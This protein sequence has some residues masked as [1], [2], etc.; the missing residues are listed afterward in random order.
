[1]TAGTG[2]SETEALRKS[3][4]ATIGPTLSRE[5]GLEEMFAARSAPHTLTTL[6]QFV[7]E[8]LGGGVE[9]LSQRIRGLATKIGFA[10]PDR[11]A[12]GIRFALDTPLLAVLVNG[13]V[14]GSTLSFEQFVTRL[15]TELGLVL[16]IGEDDS[17]VEQLETETYG[18]HGRSIYDV[19]MENEQVLRQRLIRTGLART[20]SDAH[21]EVISSDA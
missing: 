8:G 14:P 17:F 5:I 4:R 3:I 15:R 21:T 2:G 10:T 12:G 16:G 11:G 18:S 9:V 13:L 6:R 1:M 20:Y 7:L 19:L